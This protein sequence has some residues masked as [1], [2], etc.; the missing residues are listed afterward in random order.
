MKRFTL[1]H[2][3]LHVGILLVL[4]ATS[5]QCSRKAKVASEPMASEPMLTSITPPPDFVEFD[6]APTIVRRV[7]PIY[8]EEARKA[9]IEGTVW[10]KIWVGKDGAPRK[11]VIQK[12]ASNIFDQPAIDAAMQMLFTPAMMRNAPADVWVAIPFHFRLR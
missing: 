6:V 3:L 11:A 5:W 2:K 4:S 8:P 1:K 12:S 7:H 10:I 9:G